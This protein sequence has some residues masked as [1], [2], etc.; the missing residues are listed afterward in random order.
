[1]GDK[2]VKWSFRLTFSFE[3]C[4]W[5]SRSF[6]FFSITW[7]FLEVSWDNKTKLKVTEGKFWTGGLEYAVFCVSYFCIKTN[8]R[9]ALNLI[10]YQTAAIERIKF[11]FSVP[12]KVQ[13]F[14]NFKGWVDDGPVTNRYHEIWSDL[15]VMIKYCSNMQILSKLDRGQNKCRKSEIT[16]N[17]F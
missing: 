14:V 10:F 17:V 1:M 3:A 2:M 16:R 8:D 7:F 9:I 12:V 6:F 4:T 13:C 15:K 5:V 11:L